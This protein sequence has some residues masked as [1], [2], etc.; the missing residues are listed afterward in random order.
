MCVNANIIF[1]ISIAEAQ[2]EIR[3][4]HI[5]MAIEPILSV[6]KSNRQEFEN[7]HYY[8]TIWRWLNYNVLSPL[9]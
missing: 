1:T 9:K 5:M 7:H 3:L 4:F 8:E 2:F 6:K